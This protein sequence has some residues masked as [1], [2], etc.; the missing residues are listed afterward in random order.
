VICYIGLVWNYIRYIRTPV[1][2]HRVPEGNVRWERV[3]RDVGG[4]VQYQEGRHGHGT[5]GYGQF[6]FLEHGLDCVVFCLGNS[7]THGTNPTGLIK[8]TLFYVT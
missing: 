3:S 8:P 5:V 6:T 7:E 1:R 4:V 2:F